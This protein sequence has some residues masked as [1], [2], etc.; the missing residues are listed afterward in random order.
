[1][2]LLDEAR[3]FFVSRYEKETRLQ[4]GDMSTVGR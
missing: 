1:M 4:A 3:L 2:G